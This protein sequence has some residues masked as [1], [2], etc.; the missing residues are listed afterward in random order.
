M[1]HGGGRSG[2]GNVFHVM[3]RNLIPPFVAGVFATTFLALGLN[4]IAHRFDPVAS[5]AKHTERFT[6]ADWCP[7]AWPIVTTDNRGRIEPQVV[8]REM[9]RV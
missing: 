7:P 1:N 3:K 4:S 9:E 2:N 8:Q 5:R 6:T